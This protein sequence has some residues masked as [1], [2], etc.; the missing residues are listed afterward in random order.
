MSQDVLFNVVQAIILPPGP[1]VALLFL[2][3]LTPT[4]PKM[5]MSFIILGLVTLYLSS[6]SATSNWL[7]GKLEIYPPVSLE[8]IAA[9]AIVVLGADRRRNALEYGGDTMNRLGLERLRYAA[10]LA[11]LTGLPVLASG[12]GS[13]PDDVPE[14]ELMA[15]ILKEFGVE[16]RWL[17]GKSQNTYENGLFASQMLK[18]VGISEILLTTHSW[19]MPRAAEAFEMAGMK[20]IPAPTGLMNP[21]HKLDYLD[22]LP[23]ASA[24][25]STFWALHEMIGR[26]W[27]RYRYYS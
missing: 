27:Y 6:I 13:W 19:H 24:L 17:E 9:K 16:A 5:R 1:S 10:K 18:A 12:G 21:D 8:K 25:Q 23:K 15:G 11:K 7:M 14:A 20:V 4:R 26:R 2:A 3:L 22:F